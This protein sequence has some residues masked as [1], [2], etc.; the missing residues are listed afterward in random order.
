M[1][2]ADIH[3]PVRPT[4]TC[5]CCGNGW[6]CETG[7]RQLLIE[8]DGA[9]AMLGLVMST[10]FVRAAEDLPVVPAGQLYHR[11]VGWIRSRPR[12]PVNRGHW[13]WPADPGRWFRL[14][15]RGHWS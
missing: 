10:H 1:G 13:A 6:P 5:V 7:R 2:A 12:R 14:A 4:W 8:Y 9:T 15:N 3:L 11:F